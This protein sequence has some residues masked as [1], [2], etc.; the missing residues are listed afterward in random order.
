ME[1]DKV[2]EVKIQASNQFLRFNC[3]LCGIST[4]HD[5]IEASIEGIGP[6]C[7][8][9]RDK[10]PRSITGLL[11]SKLEELRKELQQF[12]ELLEYKI[13]WPENAAFDVVLSNR[14]KWDKE[15]KAAF[16]NSDPDFFGGDAANEDYYRKE[17]EKLKYFNINRINK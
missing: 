15:A 3:S 13:E 1:E 9:C 16:P 11:H 10:G 2:L 5:G 7:P 17:I 14:L 6:I 8:Q 4:R 12:K